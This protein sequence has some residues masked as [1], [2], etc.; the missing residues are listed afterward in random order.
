MKKYV[1]CS[2]THTRISRDQEMS[3]TL[4]DQLLRVL[5]LV[6]HWSVLKKP[7]NKGRYSQVARYFF[8]SLLNEGFATNPLTHTR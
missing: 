6:R 2:P 4:V 3:M 5:K 7:G 1:R 8:N